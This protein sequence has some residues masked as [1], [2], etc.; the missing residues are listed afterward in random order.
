MKAKGSKLPYE[1]NLVD[2]LRLLNRRDIFQFRY[3]HDGEH[4]A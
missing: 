3:I 1:I 2:G 4:G